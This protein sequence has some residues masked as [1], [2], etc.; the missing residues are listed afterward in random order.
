MTVELP[1]DADAALGLP[2]DRLALHLLRDIKATS[3]ADANW[4]PN[5]Y[6]FLNTAY[7]AY[8]QAGLARDQVTAVTQAL[9]EAYD[10]LLLH[11]LL[12]IAPRDYNSGWLFVTRKGEAV[13]AESDGVQL[14]QAEA[15]LDVDMHPRIAQDA[16]SL[17]L[18]GRYEFAA[19][20]AMREVEIRVREL[21]GTVADDDQNIGVKLMTRAFNVKEGGPLVDQSS[22]RG[23][24]VAMMNLFQGAIG[25]FKNPP[26]HRQVDYANPTIASEIVLFADLLMRMLDDERQR[27]V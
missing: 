22:D 25:V 14:V 12:S 5:R 23:E 2:V 4:Q 20:A 16:R 1:I 27:S 10:W 8:S 26:S 21:A 19:L 3:E 13:L 9:A 18:L 11:S 17:F 15:R 7:A 6:N 24:Q